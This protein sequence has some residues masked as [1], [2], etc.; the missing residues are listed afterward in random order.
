VIVTGS[1]VGEGTPVYGGVFY[2]PLSAKVIL[3]VQMDVLVECIVPTV[4][5][6]FGARKVEHQNALCSIISF[7]AADEPNYLWS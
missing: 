1:Q 3:L 2:K 7:Y 6:R 4:S 5:G